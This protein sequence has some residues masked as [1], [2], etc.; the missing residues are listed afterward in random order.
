MDDEQRIEGI[1]G[2]MRAC[3]CYDL[4][5]VGGH[6]RWKGQEESDGMG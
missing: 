5:L 2:I 1:G 4:G 3:G 6:S